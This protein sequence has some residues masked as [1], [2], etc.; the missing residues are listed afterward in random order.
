MCIRDRFKGLLALGNSVADDE[1]NK[2]T[3]LSVA[4]KAADVGHGAKDLNLHKLWS[5]RVVE[6]FWSQGDI[7]SRRNLPVSPL[8]DRKASNVAK[9]QEGFL[10]AIVLP[11]YEAFS[12][13]LKSEAVTKSCVDQVKSNAVYW[14]EEATRESEGRST[15]LEETNSVVSE[16]EE[17]KQA[18][19]DKQSLIELSLL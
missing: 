18:T 11:L 19:A 6:E 9:S 17:M 10:K 7:E 8:C 3:V 1:A 13:Y 4:L 15:F 12:E 14:A 5:R 16:I 2:L